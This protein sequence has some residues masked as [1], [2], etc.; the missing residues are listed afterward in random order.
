MSEIDRDDP[1][2]ANLFK[3]DMQALR[4]SQDKE[5]LSN[6]T[7]RFRAEMDKCVAALSMIKK[8]VDGIV[9]NAYNNKCDDFRNYVKIDDDGTVQIQVNGTSRDRQSFDLHFSYPKA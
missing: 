7:P 6:T 8:K 1:R 9:K 2:Y 5:M 4:S 3:K